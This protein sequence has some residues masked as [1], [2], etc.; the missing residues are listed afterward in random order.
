MHKSARTLILCLMGALV[1]LIPFSSISFSNVKAKEFG[2]YE[3][4]DRY[5]KFPTEIN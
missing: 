1:M 4:D 2:S 5:S 3:D